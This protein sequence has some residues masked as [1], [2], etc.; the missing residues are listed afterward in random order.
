[1][2]SFIDSLNSVNSQIIA[3]LVLI[4]GCIM[5]IECKRNG[6][7]PTIAGGIV[8]VASNMLTNLYV[9]RNNNNQTQ[10]EE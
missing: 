3:I 6:I 4:I 5:I 8:G 2:Q 1:M 10:K 7:D 9:K